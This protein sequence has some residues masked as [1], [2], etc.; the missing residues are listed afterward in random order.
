[1]NYNLGTRHQLCD[2]ILYEESTPD[3]WSRKSVPCV[4]GTLPGDLVDSTGT[5]TTTVEDIVGIALDGVDSVTG[6]TFLGQQENTIIYR[7]A[8]IKNLGFIESEVNKLATLKIT[9]VNYPEY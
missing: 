3:R 7:N 8:Q 6:L 4:A 9:V 2:F 5:K 1:M